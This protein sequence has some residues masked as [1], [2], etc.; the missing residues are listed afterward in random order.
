MFEKISQFGLEFVLGTIHPDYPDA[1]VQPTV[2]GQIQ[3][4]INE[5]LVVVL[6]EGHRR[7]VIPTNSAKPD[8]VLGELA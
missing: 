6:Q 1:H 5:G 4:F 2:K 8:M 3:S 7:L